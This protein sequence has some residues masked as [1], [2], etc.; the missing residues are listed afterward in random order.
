ML[1]SVPVSVTKADTTVVSSIKDVRE[2]DS[3]GQP[4]NLN[5]TF[6]R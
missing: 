4:V 2:S 1:E 5:K 3:K 6:S